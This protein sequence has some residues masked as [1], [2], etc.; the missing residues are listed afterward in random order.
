MGM[1]D[2]IPVRCIRRRLLPRRP[3]RDAALEQ[4]CTM[5][6]SHRNAHS[7][8]MVLTPIPDDDGQLPYYHPKVSHLAF[9]HISSAVH[10]EDDLHLYIHNS[11][12]ADQTVIDTHSKDDAILRVDVVPL[13]GADTSLDSRLYRTCLALLDTVHRYGWGAIVNYQ[14]RVQHDCI[15]PREL[16]QDTYLLMRERHKHLVGTWQ[17]ATDPLKHVFEVRYIWLVTC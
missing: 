4:L 14:K 15:I 11:V 8:T 10:D 16:Y 2:S 17:E 5:Y 9:R 6:A 1:K 13:E 7:H 12:K 3:A